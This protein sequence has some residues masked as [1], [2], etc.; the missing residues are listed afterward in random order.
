M[1]NFKIVIEDY[2][3]KRSVVVAANSKYQALQEVKTHG[4][5]EIKCTTTTESP[6]VTIAG[7]RIS[8]RLSSFLNKLDANDRH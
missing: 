6:V 3:G 1:G 5:A 2:Y 4:N 8:K 7:F